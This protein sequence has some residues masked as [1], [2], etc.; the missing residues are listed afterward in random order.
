MNIQIALLLSILAGLGTLL[1]SILIFIPKLNKRDYIPLFLSISATIMLTFSILD[2]IPESIIYIRSNT[3]PLK[4]LFLILI[5]FISGVLVI[6]ILDKFYKEN[7]NLKKIGILSFISLA[8]HNFPEGIATFLSSMV[9]IRLGVSL[10]LGIMLHNI[11][12]GICISLPLYQATKNKKKVLLT[13]FIASIAEPTGAIISYIFLKNYINN[14]TISIIL[15]FVAGLMITLS[16]NNIYKEVLNSKK[17]LV[18]GI[19]IGLIISLIALSV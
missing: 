14:L 11:P 6:K 17:Y 13:T 7:N 4:S 18:R 16:I 15:L 12:E 9:S 8:I 19:I 5:P 3:R 2:L 1:G 10:S